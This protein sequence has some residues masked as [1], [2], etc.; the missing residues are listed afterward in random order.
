MHLISGPTSR[1]GRPRTRIALAIMALLTVIG[2]ACVPPHEGQP[3]PAPRITVMGDSLAEQSGAHI[4]R[5]L[6]R[7]ASS[8]RL[9][10]PGR[11]ADE[12]TAAAVEAGLRTDIAVIVLGTNDAVQIADGGWTLDQTFGA[13]A[14]LRDSFASARCVVIVTVGRNGPN[15]AA[16]AAADR[17]N[18]WWHLHALAT[19]GRY[20]FA[21]WHGWL[22]THGGWQAN[23]FDGVHPRRDSDA[24][25]AM[26]DLID[27]AARSCT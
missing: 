9:S 6:R 11:R 7:W 24:E 1:V 3:P 13:L 17:I 18:F 21:D 23:T 27:E 5:A 25:R 26:A 10:L 15:L 8:A 12:L 20:R 2:A 14:S 16:N 22:E 4:D 19:P